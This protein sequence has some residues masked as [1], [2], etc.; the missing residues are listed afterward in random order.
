MGVQCVLN[1]LKL[2]HS[3]LFGEPYVYN[4]NNRNKRLRFIELRF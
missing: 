4:D 3:F 1:I 2:L